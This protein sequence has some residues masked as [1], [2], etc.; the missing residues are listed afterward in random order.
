MTLLKWS[1]N[2]AVDIEELDK[3]HRTIIGLFNSVVTAIDDE[4]HQYSINLTCSLLD[5]LNIHFG[6]EEELMK[7]HGYP[8]FAT[9]KSKHTDISKTI[10][11]LLDLRSDG[12]KKIVVSV[13]PI[14]NIWLEDHLEGE[15]KKL[16][17][18][19]KNKGVT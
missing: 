9:H 13:T 6:Y 14:F 1:G 16:G 11:N 3:Q 2:I 10:L 17:E 19:L 15:D 12:K 7:I 4:K 18:Y 8:D 5:L